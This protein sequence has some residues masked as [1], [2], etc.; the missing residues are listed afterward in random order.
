MKDQVAEIPW[1][2]RVRQPL[3]HL[4]RTVD[5]VVFRQKKRQH[6]A[7]EPKKTLEANARQVADERRGEPS[8]TLGLGESSNGSGPLAMLSST[9]LLLCFPLTFA[10]F[11]QFLEYTACL[12]L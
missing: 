7:G 3:P 4:P 8:G 1:Q 11:A 2:L 5:F 10:G 9:M 12:R 6:A